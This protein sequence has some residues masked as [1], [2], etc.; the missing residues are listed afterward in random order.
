MPLSRIRN[1]SL[2][3]LNSVLAHRQKQKQIAEKQEREMF[4]PKN[5]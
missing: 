3:D 4:Q 1:T 2:K 5:V